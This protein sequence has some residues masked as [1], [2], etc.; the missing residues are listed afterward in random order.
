LKADTA[1]ETAQMQA[2]TQAQARKGTKT[3]RT[4]A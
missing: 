3:Q 1:R 2:D 4:G